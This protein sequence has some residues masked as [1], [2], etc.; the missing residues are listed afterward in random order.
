M[1]EQLM[2]TQEVAKLLRM[3]PNSLKTARNRNTILIP[4][5]QVSKTRVLYKRSDVL[6]WLEANTK[7]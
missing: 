2:T 4:F 7:K 3:T 1:D 5:V 6:A